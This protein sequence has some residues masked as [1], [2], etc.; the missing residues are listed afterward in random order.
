LAAVSDTLTSVAERE[1]PAAKA[2]RFVRAAGRAGMAAARELERQN[3]ARPEPVPVVAPPPPPALRTAGL[4]GSIV[5]AGFFAS[6]VAFVLVILRVDTL[7]GSSSDRLVFRLV[8]AVVLL[9]E[10]ALL[11]SNWRGAN[12]RLGQ[13]VLN[14]MWGPRGA[15]TRREKTF[16]RLLRDAITLVGIAFLGT[17]VYALLSSI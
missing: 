4:V 17:A 5:F 15:V 2:G 3:A 1:H 7:V 10:A 9:A 11:T 8:V 13:R 16:A 12:Q 14:R 6:L